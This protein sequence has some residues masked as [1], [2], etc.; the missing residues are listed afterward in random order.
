MYYHLVPLYG[1]HTKGEWYKKRFVLGPVFMDTRDTRV[2]LSRQ[3][4]LY[5]IFS[6]LQEEGRQ[7]TWFIPFY[8]HNYDS[9]SHLTIAS[10]ALL[11]PY[12]FNE[13]RPGR[14]ELHIWPFYGNKEQ[15]SYR[16]YSTLW[17]LI[18]FG[19]EPQSESAM[20]HI[21]LY[22]NE[23]QKDDVFAAF[24][25][26]WLHRTTPVKTHDASLFLHWYEN[27]IQREMTRT[28]LLWLWPDKLSL[29]NYQRE[30]HH[31]Q[32]TLFPVYSY[33]RNDKTD[34]LRWFFL[35][36]L[37]QHSARGDY[38]QQTGFL[39]KVLSYEQQDADTRDFRFLWRFIRKSKTATSST[40]EFNPLYYHESEEGKGSYWTILGGL[41]GAET[42]P[43]G[44]RNMRFLWIF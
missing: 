24:F 5:P 14:K 30:P 19:S 6:R 21:L 20:T 44:E 1:V 27:D 38:V 36:P 32:H 18:R 31:L 37:F 3:D 25:P 7:R 13:E 42:T 35:W 15:G 2:G 8:Y 17:P 33:D 39:W 22:Y 29:F 11:P 10:L 16:E 43:D 12:Y 9:N 40:F 41:I 4:F 23:K 26:L 34:A 28:S